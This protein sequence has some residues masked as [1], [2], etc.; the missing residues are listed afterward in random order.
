MNHSA[1]LKQP[2]QITGRMVLAGFIAFFGLIFVV[3]G[4]LAYFAINTWPGLTHDNAYK[5]GLA[6]NDVLADGARQRALGWSSAT[7]LKNGQLVVEIT[8]KRGQ[9]VRGLTVRADLTR[10]VGSDHVVSIT[11]PA[12]ADGVYVAPISLPEVGRW[13]VDITAQS[14]DENAYRMRHKLMIEE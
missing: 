10:P 14:V 1:V 12:M 8:D 4:F 9:P 7:H 3:N 2:R 11:F 6:Y 13:Y 5:D